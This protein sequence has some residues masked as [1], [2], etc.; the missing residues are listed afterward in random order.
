M[1]SPFFI[2]IFYELDS[3]LLFHKSMKCTFRPN[4][5]V[6]RPSFDYHAAF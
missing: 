1:L 4:K 5:F 6:K 3:E 2:E